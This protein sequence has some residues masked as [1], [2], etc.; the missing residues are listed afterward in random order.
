MCDP[1]E[2]G[3][4]SAQ[5]RRTCVSLFQDNTSPEDQIRIQLV[6]VP[7]YGILTRTQPRQDPQELSEYSSFTMDDVSEHRLR[8][9]AEI[10]ENQHIWTF[11]P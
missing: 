9:E 10:M 4:G 11:L 1:P 8:W 5:R 2:S 7:M 6:S 3:T